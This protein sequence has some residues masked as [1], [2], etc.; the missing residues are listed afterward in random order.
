MRF[1]EFYLVSL[2]ISEPI[3]DFF[4][5]IFNAG[6]IYMRLP[7]KS[8]R[9]PILLCLVCDMTRF[10]YS[11]NYP[12]VMLEEFLKKKYE[13]IDRDVE[14]EKAGIAYIVNLVEQNY[15]E[16]SRV[17][18]ETDAEK[19]YDNVERLIRIHDREYCRYVG[20]TTYYCE[21]E[22]LP[23]EPVIELGW[24]NWNLWFKKANGHS[25]LL[26]EAGKQ[27]I[28]GYRKAKGYCS[29]DEQYK[30]NKEIEDRVRKEAV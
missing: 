3:F 4:H 13:E 30:I 29:L 19:L 23:K 22:K 1:I 12:T 24:G 8:G 28:N 26:T 27:V 20:A 9:I 15:D 7:E 6:K 16:F 14:R 11:H 5:L 17:F 10:L 21:S 25:I 2:I 18:S